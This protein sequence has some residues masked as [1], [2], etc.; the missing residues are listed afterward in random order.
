MDALIV[1]PERLRPLPKSMWDS[2][3][4]KCDKRQSR[5]QFIPV[6]QDPRKGGLL[7]CSLCWLYESAWGERRRADID[8]MVREVEVQSGEIF[9]RGKNGRLWSCRDADRILGAIAMTSRM[10]LM[11][12]KVQGGEN[13]PR[14]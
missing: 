3:C 14:R 10:F 9:H 11:R 1:S 4:A 13:G 7:M 8:E 5:W 6:D 2:N 12:G